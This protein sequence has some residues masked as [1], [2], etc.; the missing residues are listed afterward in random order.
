MTCHSICPGSV[1]TPSTEGRVVRLME[2]GNLLA[3]AGRAAF[4]KGK[5][6]GGRFVSPKS[7]TDLLVFLCGP[8]ARDMTGAM[9]PVEAG[10]LAS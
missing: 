9:L 4:L 1:L 10:W 8:I 3:R 6:P 7:I 5:Q 2:D